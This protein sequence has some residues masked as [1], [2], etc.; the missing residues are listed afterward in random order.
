M[1]KEIKVGI[2]DLNVTNAPNKLITVGVGSCLGITLYDKV[3][4]NGGLLH[5][6]LP[7]ST[8][9][10]SVTNPYKFVDLGVPALLKKIQDMG[11]RKDDLVAKIA[12]G[13]SMFNFSDKSILMDVGNKNLIAV[14][15][16]LEELEIPLIG[17]EIG[18]NKGRTLLLDTES[19]S[20]QIRT[21][22]M[23]LREI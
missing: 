13:A 11:S 16:I 6:M 3:K 17:E 15:R 5:V 20:V 4:K 14:K 21:K 1:C 18:G 2:A 22:D 8:Q 12:G 19:G 10:P 9:F 7:D 23:E